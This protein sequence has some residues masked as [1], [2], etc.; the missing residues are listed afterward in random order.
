[1]SKHLRYWWICNNFHGPGSALSQLDFKGITVHGKPILWFVKDYRGDVQTFVDD[2]Y[3]S[4]QREKTHHEWQQSEAIAA[5]YVGKLSAPNGV[6]VDF[7]AGGATTLVAA[8]KLGRRF[9]GYEIDATHC[10]SANARIA[11]V[12][13]SLAS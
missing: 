7:F 13:L 2:Y 5:Y 3:V 4:P 1:M 10:E 9:F 6:V 8:K 12:N 11:A